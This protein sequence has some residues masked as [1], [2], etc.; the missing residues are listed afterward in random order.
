MCFLSCLVMSCHVMSCRLQK[1]DMYS[2][3]V[4]F[5]EMCHPPP[6]TEMERQ[7]LLTAL[8]KDPPE[9]PKLFSEYKMKKKVCPPHPLTQAAVSCSAIVDY[10]ISL[11]VAQL[12]SDVICWLL[13][14]AP[15]RRPTAEALLQSEYIPPKM[16][17]KELLEVRLMWLG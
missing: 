7:H 16:E 8:R 10:T 2:L 1:V 17:D 4:I 6:S 15:H 11:C 9:L 3:G 13:D 14:H 12:Q 5:F